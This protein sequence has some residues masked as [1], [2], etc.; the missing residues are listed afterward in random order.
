M[1]WG[2]GGGEGGRGGGEYTTKWHNK[3]S[4]TESTGIKRH[5]LIT[6]KILHIP[7][8]FLNTKGSENKREK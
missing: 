6:E 3:K 1:C 5:K 7:H 2:G 4:K 8:R